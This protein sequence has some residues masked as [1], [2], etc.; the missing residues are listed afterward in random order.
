MKNFALTVA[1]LTAIS[2]SPLLAGGLADLDAD[3]SGTLSMEELQA[4]FPDLTEETFGAIDA[5]ADG[6]VDMDE[7]QAAVEAGVL[8]ATG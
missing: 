2:A 8:P 1:T 4:V 5:N 7:A 3:A 6:D